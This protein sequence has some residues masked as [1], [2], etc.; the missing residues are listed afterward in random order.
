MVAF[1]H[2]HSSGRFDRSPE[3]LKAAVLKYQED[4][5]VIT[6]TEVSTG[7]RKKAVRD[8]NGDA[9]SAVIGDQGNHNDGVVVFNKSKY[10][11]VYYENH[12]AANSTYFRKNGHRTKPIY[13]TIV[14]LR[15]IKTDKYFVMTVIHLASSVEGDLYHKHKTLRT[16]SWLKT[17]RGAKNRTNL[18][19]K[20][21]KAQAAF[22]IADYNVNFKRAWARAVVKAVA[23]RYSNNWKKTAVVGGTH[24][25]RIIDATLIKGKAVSFGG[26]KL[27][28]NDDSSDH[29]PYIETLRLTQ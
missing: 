20:R 2:I 28:A 13:A 16:I 18:L 10:A 23:P 3:S 27:Y 12:K 24:G 1:V 17:F 8:A 15:E 22:F 7:S 5:D 26:A 25:N 9:F 4:A 21:Y 19:K 29:R 14:V 6:L 11:L